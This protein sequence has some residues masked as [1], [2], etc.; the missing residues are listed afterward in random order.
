MENY[1]IVQVGSKQYTIKEGDML[2]TELVS[3]CEVGKSF[4]SDKILIIAKGDDLKIGTPFVSGAKVKFNVA[5]EVK[6]KKV[7][8]F[9]YRRRN[10]S[11]MRRGHRQR[12]FN[13]KVEKITG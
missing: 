10:G 7:M 5:S 12:K 2:K 3:G 8:T 6:E 13:L 1:A 9:K 4:E 11:Q